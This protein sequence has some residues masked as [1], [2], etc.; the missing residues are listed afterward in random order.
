MAEIDW[1]RFACRVEVELCERS[2]SYDA[3]VE[4]WPSLNK[5]LL[6][7]A[8]NAKPLSAGNYQHLCALLN[9]DPLAFLIVEKRK[10]VTMKSV[11]EHAVTDVV[12]RETSGHR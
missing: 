1:L 4:K 9:L 12:R 3:A 5:G 8:C 6:S 2:L 7:R 10:R 11:L